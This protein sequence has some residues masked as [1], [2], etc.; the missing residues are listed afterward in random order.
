M[1]TAKQTDSNDETNSHF[2]NFS[3]IN[4]VCV[5]KPVVCERSCIFR[6]NTFVYFGKVK[7]SLG[8][9]A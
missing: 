5:W 7:L 6:N 2:F 4:Y 3:K 8:K 9:Y 1:R